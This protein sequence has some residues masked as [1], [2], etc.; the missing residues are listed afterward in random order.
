MSH[1]LNAAFFNRV[2]GGNFGAGV[3]WMTGLPSDMPPTPD[4]LSPPT[5]P[6]YE[7]GRTLLRLRSMEANTD[8]D[9]WAVMLVAIPGGRTNWQQFAPANCAAFHGGSVPAL[10]HIP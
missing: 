2:M 9:V 6:A 8:V 3:G 7:I 1:S 5:R 4:A 10:W